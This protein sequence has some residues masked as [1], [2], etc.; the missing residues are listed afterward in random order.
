MVMIP[1]GYD[2][3]EVFGKVVSV[4]RTSEKNAPYPP[5]STKRILRKL[6]PDQN[7]G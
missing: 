6:V 1:Y 3:R 2:N 7:R 4:R 5:E